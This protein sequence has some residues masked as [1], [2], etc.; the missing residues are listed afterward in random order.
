MDLKS[1]PRDIDCTHR[2]GV[3]NKGKNR[4]I[5]IKF[6]RYMDWKC[7]FSNKK[8]LKGKNMS[9]TESLRKI[10]MS[11]LKKARSKFGYSSVW[12]ADR[13]TMYKVEGNTKAK[14]YFD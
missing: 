12:T 10:E 1:L 8:R 2:I 14:V 7:I 4:P 6:G 5:I 3:L 13:R 9:I 11:G